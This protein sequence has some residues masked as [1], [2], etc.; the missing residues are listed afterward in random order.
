MADGRGEPL[1][2]L[3]GDIS[4]NGDFSGTSDGLE[5]ARRLALEAKNH[6]S[7]NGIFLMETGEYNADAAAVF[8]RL[9]NFRDIKI[10]RDLEGEKRVVIAGV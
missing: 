4:E 3:D 5:V 2:A 7:P 10:E 6:L 8:L 9:N 1:L